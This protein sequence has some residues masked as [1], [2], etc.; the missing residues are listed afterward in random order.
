MRETP[1]TSTDASW[2]EPTTSACPPRFWWL[3]RFGALFAALMLALTVL[4]WWW[5]YEA[6]FIADARSRGEPV[7]YDD[8][9]Q[10]VVPDSDNAVILLND[11]V[12]LTRTL[13]GEI[14]R[15]RPGQTLTPSESAL[16]QTMLANSRDAFRYVRDARSRTWFQWNA[17]FRPPMSTYSVPQLNQLRALAT[18]LSIDGDDSAAIEHIRDLCFLGEALHHHPSVWFVYVSAAGHR[19]QA[20]DRIKEMACELR[21]A[22]ESDSS[23]APARSATRAQVRA[24]IDDLLDERAARR[25]AH[26]AMFAE[27][28]FAL[29]ADPAS[30]F[31][32]PE[33]LHAP[34]R[35]MFV[36]D[37]LRVAA[38]YTDSARAIAQ[39]NYPAAMAMLPAQRFDVDD[40][41]DLPR[42]AQ[43]TRMAVI[44]HSYQSRF[45]EVHYRQCAARRVAATLLAL[46]LYQLDH[47]G[48]MPRT[49]DEFDSVARDGVDQGGSDKPIPGGRQFDF[50]DLVWRY[51]PSTQP[52][53]RDSSDEAVDD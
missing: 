35:P 31:V 2:I 3:K 26:D 16:V 33:F 15:Y 11:A 5:G 32:I 23:T 48:Q 50:E 30:M 52:A 18:Y 44:L 17:Q 37:G 45:I 47:A 43:L 4:R 14:G 19:A 51:V 13:L 27:R 12:A 36:L 29:E 46:P 9:A 20:I 53:T 24:L 10:P 7:W 25:Q 8:F 38:N 34:L 40:L 22:N 28:L 49:L 42:P 6:G 1:A 21:I 41:D 39:P